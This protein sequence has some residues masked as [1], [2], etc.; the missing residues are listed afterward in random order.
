M[1]R[2]RSRVRVVGHTGVVPGVS[3]GCFSDQQ[4]A[5]GATLRLLRL[6]ADAAARR[7]EVYHGT[8]VVPEKGDR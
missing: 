3:Q 4:L 2:H 8:A 6:Q 1:H 5:G 7:V